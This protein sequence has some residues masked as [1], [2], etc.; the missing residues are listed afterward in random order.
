MHTGGRQ[1]L[2][3][4]TLPYAKQREWQ[5]AL[6]PTVPSKTNR[7]VVVR[8]NELKRNETNRNEKFKREPSHH[9]EQHS[10]Q[11]DLRWDVCVRLWQDAHTA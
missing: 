4:P 9:A 1:C 3:L 5:L 2:S 7:F 11:P 6:E 10:F 8:G